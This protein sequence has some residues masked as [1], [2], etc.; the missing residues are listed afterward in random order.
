MTTETTT[1]ALTAVE[2]GISD[3]MKALANAEEH[4]AALKE[5]A[6]GDEPFVLAVRALEDWHNLRHTGVLRV[7]DHG[8]CV[9]VRR[10][11]DL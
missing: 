4:I 11:V 5:L 7:C 1:E 8:P 6:S 9:D 10:V 2:R 3:T